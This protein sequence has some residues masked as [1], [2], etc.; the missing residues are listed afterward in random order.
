MRRA[1]SGAVNPG[2]EVLSGALVADQC[3]EPAGEV[4]D[5]VEVRA[6]VAGV[7]EV[8]GEPVLQCAQAALLAAGKDLGVQVG[9]VVD[10]IGEALPQ[11]GVERAR[12]L[13]RLG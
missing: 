3:G 10:A 8:G 5:G 13:G 9:G 12:T 4:G 11:V 1:V 6:A 2:V 7:G